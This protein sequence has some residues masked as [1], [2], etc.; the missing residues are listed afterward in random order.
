MKK[1]ARKLKPIPVRECPFCGK[2]PDGNCFVSTAYGPALICNHCSANG[3]AS[4][5]PEEQAG[6]EFERHRRGAIRQWNTRAV[7][8]AAD[9][10]TPLRRKDERRKPGTP[11]VLGTMLADERRGHTRRDGARRRMR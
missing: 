10:R 11:F 7:E 3:P 8:A 1:R 9:R 4:E 5:W 6:L 2:V